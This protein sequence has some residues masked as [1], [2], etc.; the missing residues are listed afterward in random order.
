MIRIGDIEKALLEYHPQA[1]IGLVRKAYIYAAKVH[2]GQVRLSGE[3]YLAH[4]LEV[5]AILT[6][7][8]LDEAAIAAGLL[9]DT[10]EDTAATM[11]DIAEMFGR[12]VALVVEG[13]TKIT[14]IEHASQDAAQ[15]EN[16]R[17]MIVAMAKDIRV[18]LVKLADRLHNMRTLGYQKQHKQAR[19][20]QE[21]LDIYA[22]WPA[23]WGFTGSR[24]SWKTC[25]CTTSSR[26]STAASSR[27]TG[28]ADRPAVGV[29]L[30]GDRLPDRPDGHQR[31]RRRGQGPTEAPLLPIY[32]KM[33][34]QQLTLDQFV[35]H[36]R[37]QNRG[38]A[39]ARLLRGPGRGPL[40]VEA[41]SGSVQGLHLPAQGQPLPVAP[42]GRG[43]ARGPPDR[44]P[45]PDRDHEQGGR[46]RHRRPLALQ[47]GRQDGRGRRRAVRLAAPAVGMAAGAVPT[48]GTFSIRSRWSCTRKRSTSSPPPARSRFCPRG[49]PRST[50]PLPSIPRWARPASGPR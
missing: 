15:S 32:K 29:R 33:I 41:D 31:H 25:A 11:E 23:G 48:R 39:S 4:P 16:M 2:E 46:G 50:S 26:S 5:T 40:P 8:R 1:D 22:P 19:I 24:A 21:T 35:R 30:P 37:L 44:D 3:P 20:A 17:K 28:P 36:H 49:R 45:D 42:H 27:G 38:Q 7:M 34:D 6:R 18:L 12:E 10:V 14:G 9:H 13:V 43:R 47:G